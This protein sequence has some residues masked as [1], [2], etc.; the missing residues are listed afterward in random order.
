M[1]EISPAS[2]ELAKDSIKAQLETTRIAADRDFDIMCLQEMN[3]MAAMQAPALSLGF[4]GGLGGGLG[5][6]CCMGGFC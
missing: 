4:A 3:L 2:R 6:C 5:G 1:V